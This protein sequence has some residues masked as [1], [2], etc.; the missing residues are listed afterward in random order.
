MRF[1][2]LC[3]R[4]SDPITLLSPHFDSSSTRMLS[5]RR[6]ITSKV[7]WCR[8]LPRT[9][10]QVQATTNCYEARWLLYHL[11]SPTR[12]PFG[13]H[14]GFLYEMLLLR[15]ILTIRP[16]QSFTIL[17]LAANVS[18][19]TMYHEDVNVKTLCLSL[20]RRCPFHVLGRRMEYR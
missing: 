2:L 3:R 16:Y 15:S 9:G 10:G 4:C 7:L 6:L 18:A 12:V 1:C 20:S 13:Q 19:Q 14:G 5:G 17:E 8:H 11:Q